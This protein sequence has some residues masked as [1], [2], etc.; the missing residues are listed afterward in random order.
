MKTNLKKLV[1]KFRGIRLEK[2]FDE[3]REISEY[4]ASNSR[5]ILSGRYT[6]HPVNVGGQ[7]Y[8]AL[9]AHCLNRHAN[10]TGRGNYRWLVAGDEARVGIHRPQG[11][12]YRIL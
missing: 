7:E 2:V 9:D 11:Q 12:G 10:Q 5:E 8:L 4:L 6:A 1:K 3:L